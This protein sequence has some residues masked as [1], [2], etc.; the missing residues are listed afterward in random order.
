MT[1]LA[2]TFLSEGVIG[3][4]ECLAL[5]IGAYLG[6]CITVVIGALGG[7]TIK[8]QVATSHV[9]FNVIFCTILIILFKPLVYLLKDIVLPF[10]HN[11]QVSENN[12]YVQVI[13]LFHIFAKAIG[14]ILFYPFIDRFKKLIERLLPIEHKHLNLR[15]DSWNNSLSLAIKQELLEQDIKDLRKKVIQHQTNTLKFPSDHDTLEHQNLVS[16][17]SSLIKAITSLDESGV[18][19]IHSKTDTVQHMM[20]ALNDLEGV[21]HHLEYLASNDNLQLKEY[22]QLIQNQY[23]DLT[24]ENHGFEK[25]KTLLQTIKSQD[26]IIL[27]AHNFSP[28]QITILSSINHSFFQCCKNCLIA[29]DLM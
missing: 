23:H 16:S 20:Y 25:Q 3:F 18:N 21:Q 24:H 28:E 19:Y 7:S 4:E 6:T 22:Y 11:N 13:S 29:K 27:D 8:K 10:I 26:N 17:A 1:I 15:I 9:L 14:V 12:N 2:L 5:I